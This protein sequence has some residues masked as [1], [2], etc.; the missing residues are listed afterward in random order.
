MQL[1]SSSGL[2]FLL[3]QICHNAIKFGKNLK[4]KSGHE[5]LGHETSRHEIS[6]NKKS[7][8]EISGHAKVWLL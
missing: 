5:K 6:G 8:H 1:F 3:R 2:H 7:G 4:I